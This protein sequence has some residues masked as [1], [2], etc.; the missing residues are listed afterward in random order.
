[1]NDLMAGHVPVFFDTLGTTVPLAQEKKIRPLAIVARTRAPQLPD[2]PTMAEAGYPD[3]EGSSWFAIFA[4]AGTPADVV[5]RLNAEANK[6]LQTP[7]MERAFSGA[8]LHRR[9]R[10]AEGASRFDED[11]DSALD[12][13]DPQTQHQGRVSLSQLAACSLQMAGVGERFGQGTSI[14]HESA[15]S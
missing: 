10:P 13:A 1:M 14:N 11:R 12:Q 2:V 4:P 3:V 6:A 15:R 8:G 9:K 5:A 7:E